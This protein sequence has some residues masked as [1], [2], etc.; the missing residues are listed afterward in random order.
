[1]YELESKLFQLFLYENDVCMG[2]GGACTS[3][4]A[5][6]TLYLMS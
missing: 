3:Q 4:I 1:M 6:L 5:L 2:V